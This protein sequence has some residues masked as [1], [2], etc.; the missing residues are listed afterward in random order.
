[1][2]AQTGRSKRMLDPFEWFMLD[3]VVLPRILSG[4]RVTE[5]PACHEA[6]RVGSES[7]QVACCPFCGFSWQ[8]D[9]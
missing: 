4:N 6:V 8:V 5:C 7:R 9:C 3:E 2:L 1:M